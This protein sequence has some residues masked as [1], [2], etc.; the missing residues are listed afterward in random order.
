MKARAQASWPIRAASSKPGPDPK[1]AEQAQAAPDVEALSRNMMRFV[2]ESGKA[3]VAYLKPLETGKSNPEFAEQVGDAV[4]TLGHIAERW[5]A[6]PAKALEAQQTLSNGFLSLWSQTLRRLSGEDAPPVVPM[7]K[8]DKRFAAPEWQANP[9]FDFLRQAYSMT[10][11]WA[12]DVVEKTEGIDPY[13]KQK[14]EFYLRQ[15]SGA[16]SPS[17]FLATNPELLRETL[18][19]NGENLVRGMHMLAEDIEAGKGQIKIR[20][21]DSSKLVLGIDMASTPGKVMFRDDL[22]E[23]IQYA[24]STETV[25]RRPLLIV[26]PW[27]NKFYVLDLNKE[28][29]FIRWCVA[30]GLTVFVVSW[31]NPDERHAQKGFEEY[32]REGILAALDA[33]ELATGERDVTALGYCVGGTLLSVT[34]AWMAAKGDARISSTT[35]LTTQ[36]DFRDA[37]DLKVFIDAERLKSLEAKMAEHGY[38][39]G[40]SMATAFNMLRPNDLIWSYVVNNYLKGKEPMPFDLLSWNSDSTRMPAANHSF[41]MRNCYIEN[42]LTRGEMELAG[43]RL[44]LGKVRIP[45][46]N[47]AAKEDHIAP[48]RSVFTGAK[49]F[50]GEMR[51][52]L[53]GSGHIAGVVNPAD[54]PKYQYWTG[55]RPEGEFDDWVRA[56]QEH[57][58]SWWVDWIAWIAAQAPEK[59]PARTP[60]DGKLT[61]I[62]DAPGE[63]VQAKA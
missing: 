52:V 57:P 29:S 18:R 9:L 63:Y 22:I 53:S 7:E 20:Q 5:L 42:N 3:A 44:D 56:A 62:C 33:I 54:K 19:Q 50:G 23:L 60:G 49:F 38:L 40:S 26:P 16:L 37:G 13:E 2:E 31:V 61:P 39:E 47:L 24:P 21:S 58:G 10:T 35:L 27:I 59:V 32:M 36:V 45:V 34:L 28:K 6:D 4:K 14:A 17:N 15:I 25:Y 51:Y 1:A 48:A 43:E 8:S 46:Y 55:P 30:Q 11:R 12:N 41:Y